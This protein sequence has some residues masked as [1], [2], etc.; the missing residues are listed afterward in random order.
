MAGAIL[1]IA[2]NRPYPIVD[3]NV[4]RVLSRVHGR[5]GESEEELWRAAG[6]LVKHA[7]PRTV[8]QAMMELGARVCSFRA[9]RCLICPIQNNCVAF[10]TGKQTE[11]PAIRKRPETV[12]VRLFAVVN[13][14]DG[15]YLMKRSKG[16]WE[17]PTFTEPPAGGLTRVGECRHTI[18]HHRLEI[19]VYSG[20][21]TD[22]TGFEWK[23]PASVP[24]SSLT[25]KILSI[26]APQL[27]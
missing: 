19:T 3:G 20:S 23:E 7:E 1:S 22:I 14:V 26:A 18:T 21:L 16:M 4:R 17:F 11:F 9:P 27:C 2:F 10:H 8:N 12:R 15:R 13:A 6:E 5:S 25:R 24:L